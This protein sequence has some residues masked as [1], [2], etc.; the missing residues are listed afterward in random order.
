MKTWYTKNDVKIVDVILTQGKEPSYGEGWLEAPNDWGGSPGDD[1][2]WFGNDMRRIPDCELVKRGIR[3][4]CRNKKFYK[5]DNPGETKKI[6][7]LDEEAGEGYTDKEPL[8]GDNSAM[9]KWDERERMWIVDNVKKDRAESEKALGEIQSK[10]AELET[11]CQRPSQEI[12]VD[13]NAEENRNWL[14]KYREEITKMRP[15]K[16]ELENKL[17]SMKTA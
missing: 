11:K 8:I 10:I 17:R 1:L 15:E 3:Q 12:L 16:E 14:K 9:Q 2:K 7:F 4:D 6:H 5:K 13:M